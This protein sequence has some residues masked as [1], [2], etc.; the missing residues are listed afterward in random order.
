[1]NK[2]A[3]ING[4]LLYVPS[5]FITAG[6]LRRDDKTCLSKAAELLARANRTLPLKFAA[7]HR[8]VNFAACTGHATV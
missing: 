3:P 2:F 7:S 4:R 5:F 1:M 8:G 6:P